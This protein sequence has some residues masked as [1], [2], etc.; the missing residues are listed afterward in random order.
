MQYSILV[1][2]HQT[3]G[4]INPEKLVLEMKA[5]NF[6]TL[7]DQYGLDPGLIPQMKSNLSVITAKGDASPYFVLKYNQKEGLPII[8]YRWDPRS[9]TGKFITREL[10]TGSLPEGVGEHLKNA[11]CIVGI[12]LYQSQMKDMGLILAYEI[13]RWVASRGQ[14]MVLGLDGVWYQLNRSSAFIPIT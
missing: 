6:S 8:V 3:L 4:K 12:E 5:V 9:E 7:C 1:I 11:S 14:G 10:L 2:N 13:A